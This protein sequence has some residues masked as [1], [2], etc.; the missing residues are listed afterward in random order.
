[1]SLKNTIFV[2]YCLFLHRLLSEIPA[3][4]HPSRVALGAT[5]AGEQANGTPF[6]PYMSHTPFLP[7]SHRFE[8][9]RTDARDPLAT[10]DAS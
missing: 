9:F 7:I 5:C 4:I 2:S 3:Q 1:M 8:S 6:L 10:D